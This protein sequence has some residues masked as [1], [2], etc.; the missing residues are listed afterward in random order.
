M[1]EQARVLLDV[2][3]LDEPI[4]RSP[5]ARISFDR[6]VTFIEVFQ[7]DMD[8]MRARADSNVI[9]PDSEL[10]NLAA[11][12]DIYDAPAKLATNG[13]G[14]LLIKNKQGALA[15]VL[16]DGAI[17][18]A[19]ILLSYAAKRISAAR[20]RRISTKFGV[21]M[22]K[23]F[24]TG[25]LAFAGWAL[26]I[27]L[28]AQL[29]IATRADWAKFTRH[30]E[31][32]IGKYDSVGISD[33]AIKRGITSLTATSGS[34]D[35]QGRQLLLTD[36]DVGIIFLVLRTS[37]APSAEGLWSL[38]YKQAKLNSVGCV[39]PVYNDDFEKIVVRMRKFTSE[40]INKVFDYTN[41]YTVLFRV[42]K[43]TILRVGRLV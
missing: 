38:F 11:L 35:K 4:T 18:S 39:V 16:M 29:L 7:P 41:I 42:G 8:L 24:K 23:V 31:Y 33:I 43:Q 40:T 30:A 27:G 36:D 37:T 9:D 34:S 21:R 13:F 14:Q 20:V 22:A 2:E 3:I 5:P 28:L 12:A 6:R 15:A 17:F 19:G 1:A 26:E 32:S 10:I 25:A